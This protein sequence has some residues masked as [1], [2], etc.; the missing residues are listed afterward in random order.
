M[1]SLCYA[2]EHSVQFFV[3]FFYTVKV[4]SLT[5]SV[6]S[7]LHYITFVCSLS[8]HSI[9]FYMFYKGVLISPQPDQEGIKLERQK[10]LSFV[11]PIYTHN[12][13]N[14]STISILLLYNKTSIKRNILTI[15]Q[16]TMG[17]RSSSGLISTPVL[18]Y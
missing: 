17:S 2:R 3:Q 4:H 12:W 9:M 8:L 1:G 15:K 18:I 5:Q 16:N 7:P 14:T 10:I 13:R 6:R 11:Y